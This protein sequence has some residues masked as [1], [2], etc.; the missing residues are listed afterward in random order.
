M[1]IFV[2]FNQRPQSMDYWTG[3]V[4]K[5]PHEIDNLASLLLLVKNLKQKENIP[6]S[7]SQYSG[8]PDSYHTLSSFDKSQ[9]YNSLFPIFEHWANNRAQ[10]QTTTTTTTELTPYIPKRPAVKRRKKVKIDDNR[11]TESLE[12]YLQELVQTVSEEKPQLG[13][14]EDDLST[15]KLLKKGLQKW[16]TKGKKKASKKAETNHDMTGWKKPGKWLDF[17]FNLDIREIIKK[18]LMTI[19]AIKYAPVVLA[20]C[21]M[22]VPYVLAK[23]HFRKWK[24]K[25]PP[26]KLV[27]IPYP[28]PIYPG[29]GQGNHMDNAYAGDNSH[30]LGSSYGQG[31]EDLEYDPSTYDHLNEQRTQYPEDM[32]LGWSNYFREYRRTPKMKQNLG[33]RNAD[34][35]NAVSYGEMVAPGQKSQGLGYKIG[36]VIKDLTDEHNIGVMKILMNDK[37]ESVS[38]LLNRWKGLKQSINN[39]GIGRKKR[40]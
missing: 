14:G 15:L 34:P 17:N 30:F 33:T 22:I 5:S 18:K 6:F 29:W 2:D 1:K 19:I 36:N 32:N 8:V 10:K 23:L 21:L 37:K 7:S 26:P 16:T 20:L 12:Q 24:Q 38:S 9:L 13:D 27:P 25:S 40:R 35:N 31:E 4:M 28:Y 11:D 3:E 39:Y